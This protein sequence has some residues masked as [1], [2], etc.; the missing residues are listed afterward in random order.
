MGKKSIVLRDI[1]KDYPAARA[2]DGVSFEVGAGTI[3]GFL[4][5]NG[6]GKS[7]TINIVTGL[8]AP[9]SGDVLVGGQSI[10]QRK[11]LP[12]ARL[13]LLPENLP[14]YPNMRVDDYLL[15]CRGIYSLRDKGGLPPL[16][17]VLEKCGLTA[18]SRRLIGNLSKGY[19]QRVGIAQALIAGP[20]IVIL[21]EPM[22]GLDPEAV[23]EIRELIQGLG[24]E[25]TVLLSSHRLPEVGMMCS[26]LTIIKGVRYSK[27][28]NGRPCGRIFPVAP[29]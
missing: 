14:L 16:I 29:T 19:R 4:G 24:G 1:V 20:E 6:A 23:T 15:F 10:F 27:V 28:G 21:D 12:T 5:P 8:V 25:H 3:H 18:V 7:T 9:T 17:V 22:S 13:G 2:L 11:R 26:H